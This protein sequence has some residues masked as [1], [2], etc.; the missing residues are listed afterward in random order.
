MYDLK[1]AVS[2][3]NIQEILKDILTEKQV[4]DLSEYIQ[5][6]ET[7]Y[8]Q[9][10]L[11]TPIDNE[12]VHNYSQKIVQI[13][14]ALESEIF[15]RL[16]QNVTEYS[17]AYYLIANIMEY[18]AKINRENKE[19]A[20]DYW[21]R[22][23][24]A[25][26]YAGFSANSVFS[27]LQCEKFLNDGDDLY[28]DLIL[29]V[30]YFLSRRFNLFKTLSNDLA[31]KVDVLEKCSDVSHQTYFLKLG[32][33][34]LI[35]TM[36]IIV[37]YMTTGELNS[38]SEVEKRCHD[39]IEKGGD[40][41]TSWLSSRLHYVF[42]ASMNRSMWS[43]RDIVPEKIIS[44]L[45]NNV[46]PIYEIWISQ[47][48]ALRDTLS[49]GLRHNA[50]I[51]MPTSAGKTLVAAILLAREILQ[52]HHN[53]FYVTPL[54]ALVN[55]AADFFS[56]Y[57]QT[58]GLTVSYL[59]GDYDS[60]PS[61][62]ELVGQNARI[63]ILT[64]EKLDLLWRVN[65]QRLESVAAIVFD[66]VQLIREQGRGMRL[67]LLIGKLNEIYGHRCRM[68]MLSAVLPK[69]NVSEFINWLGSTTT[70]VFESIW[71]PTRLREG[72]FFRGSDQKGNVL[73]FR[74]GS[75]NNTLLVKNVLPPNKKPEK[76]STKIKRVEPRLDSAHLAWR[77]HFDFGPVLV[78]TNKRAETEKIAQKIYDLSSFDSSLSLNGNLL[79]AAK[80]IREILNDRF[81]LPDMIERGIAYHHASMPEDV[82]QIIQKLAK[83]RDL[84]II[85]STTT[86][87]EG[88][89][90][91][92][93]SVIINT[94]MAGN[95]RM[96]AIRLRNLAGRA[97]R[98]LRDTE[99]HVIILHPDFVDDLLDI[100][101]STIRSRFFN[102][103]ET[104]SDDPD[105]DTDANALEANLLS[106]A[107]K[108]EFSNTDTEL[109]T[110]KILNSTFFSKQANS[111]V[112]R[113]VY[114]KILDRVTKV[115]NDPI[116]EDRNILRIFSETGLNLDRCKSL[117]RKARE[118][119]E[120]NTLSL[121]SNNELNWEIVNFVIK[122]CIDTSS[123]SLSKTMLESIRDP[124]LVIKMWISGS[125]IFEIANKIK[126]DDISNDTFSKISH[127]L[128]G[129]V[130]SDLS[131]T[132]TAFVKLLTYYARERGLI[133]ELDGEWELLPSY[134]KYGTVNS[135]S[136][137]LMLSDVYERDFA[138]T[139]GS[140][141]KYVS[142]SPYDW[143][144]IIGW[145]AYVTNSDQITFE[146]VKEKL[147]SRLD[148]FSLPL[149]LPE[150][151][152]GNLSLKSDGYIYENNE[153]ITSL[154]P[155]LMHLINSIN[156]YGNCLTSFHE[157]VDKKW[158]LQI[159][160]KWF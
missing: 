68:I 8:I 141:N 135:S 81:S 3:S 129:Y 136:L 157:N 38:W 86:L 131:W 56:K 150:R 11:G 111:L 66:E 39:F 153:K 4:Y 80:Q 132:V 89:N 159:K 30:I 103:L 63:Y 58:I 142:K 1:D 40:D 41:F 104:L 147:I 44:A 92:I 51:S 116:L 10:S 106:R 123:T 94:P 100:N 79:N 85:V 148:E 67:E 127:F 36:D 122:T 145:I 96:D 60:I 102:Y 152:Y 154:D 108:K 121:R 137:L 59:P 53:A 28:H 87:A 120:K 29:L 113:K 112:Y 64:P 35:R 95:D 24:L 91:N 107:Y 71:S 151:I 69:S 33:L 73:Y 49:W 31:K 46:D 6:L 55:E 32:F 78:Y 15:I 83:N 62:E 48:Q 37:H 90:L 65:D 101:R 50:V 143:L 134:I 128:Y 149:N 20:I 75:K 118:L 43:I 97:G 126:P 19:L 52:N 26:S 9:R 98:A 27:A 125:P 54:R 156:S 2:K 16:K 14:I 146:K 138:I 144:K 119:V 133:L 22:A 82:K 84:K 160:I 17:D 110:K 21:L 88:V 45:I 130:M 13:S 7:L 72:L 114:S 77:Y 74:G 139:K 105:F 155:D 70:G 109:K 42:I 124:L 12:N 76:D 158:Y 140:N 5:S 93:K 61:L 115:V 25:Y 23:S 57:F 34:G 99:G 18:A 117:E 47:E